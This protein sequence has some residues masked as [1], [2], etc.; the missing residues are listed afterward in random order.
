MS[1]LKPDT[2]AHDQQ[3]GDTNAKVT[4]VEYGDYQCPHCGHAYPLI[5]QLIRDLGNKLHFVFRNF[6]LSEIHP[7]AIP[8]AIAAE[9]AGL[10]DKFL[11]NARHDIRKP[12]E[13]S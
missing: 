3:L 1:R 6:P 9:A 8:A 11:A 2:N 5:K 12:S 7:L 4:L 10:Q 13:A